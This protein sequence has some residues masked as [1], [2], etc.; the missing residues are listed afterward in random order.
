MI[1]MKLKALKDNQK[2]TNF[3]VEKVQKYLRLFF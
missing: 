1:F 2:K 3:T